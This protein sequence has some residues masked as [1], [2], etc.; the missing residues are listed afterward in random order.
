MG[1]RGGFTVGGR[2]YATQKD[3]DPF[4]GVAGKF[5]S[6]DNPNVPAVVRDVATPCGHYVQLAWNGHFP[7]NYTCPVCGKTWGLNS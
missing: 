1:S 5:S 2:Q 6:T 4:I 3:G 7:I